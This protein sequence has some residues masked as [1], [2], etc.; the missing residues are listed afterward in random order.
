MTTHG[1]RP[2]RLWVCLVLVALVLLV[3]APV[4]RFDFVN[5]DDNEYVTENPFVRSGLSAGNVHWALTALHSGHWHPLTWLSLALDCQLF[6]LHAGAPH[7]VNV[8]LHAAAAALLFLWVE[9]A[10]G[11]RW[12]SA[13]LAA[14][15]TLHPLRV[16]SVAWVTG[17]KDVL[18]G[19][20]LM[21]TLWAYVSYTEHESWRGYAAVVIA[22]ALGLLAKPTVAVAPC[23]LLLLDYWP[24]GRLAPTAPDS[25]AKERSLGWLLVEKAPLFVMAAATLTKDPQRLRQ[26][27]RQRNQELHLQLHQGGRWGLSRQRLEG[28]HRARRCPCRRCRQVR[29][30]LSQAGEHR[31]PGKDALGKDAGDR[32]LRS[33]HTAALHARRWGKRRPA[34][35]RRAMPPAGRRLTRYSMPFRR[36][37]APKN[38]PLVFT[39]RCCVG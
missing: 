39:M 28:G 22:F 19:L 34:T 6:G 36:A 11:S 32:P 35:P 10:T 37:T 20:F 21:L 14:L 8:F 38:R 12:R 13:F 17:R 18:S 16:E 3:Y 7:V 2:V 29:Q 27:D 15:F 9:R 30:E 5:L 26:T 31:R 23:V 24:L 33:R 25:M 4:R 1:A